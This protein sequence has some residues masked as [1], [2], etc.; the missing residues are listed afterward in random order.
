MLIENFDQNKI[1][2]QGSSLKDVTFLGREGFN[3]F[4]TRTLTIKNMTMGERVE[5]CSKL[6]DVVYERPQTGKLAR[7]PHDCLLYTP[8][9]TFHKQ[10]LLKLQICSPETGLNRS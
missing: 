8:F 6:R 9:Q 4:V 5:N 2:G 7:F 3:D 10:A 1:V